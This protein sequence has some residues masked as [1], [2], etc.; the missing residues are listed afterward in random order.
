[1]VIDMAR[2]KLLVLPGESIENAKRREGIEAPFGRC[3]DYAEPGG[4][5]GCGEPLDD[6]E[7]DVCPDYPD[8]C[9]P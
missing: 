7:W 9:R 3:G 6:G 8:C 1:M 5:P 2:N 4:F